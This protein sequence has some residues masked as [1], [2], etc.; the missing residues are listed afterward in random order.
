ML[1]LWSFLLQINTANIQI[2][3]RPINRTKWN[4][5]I[6]VGDYFNAFR[7]FNEHQAF[8]KHLHHKYPH[9][10]MSVV[11][12]SSTRNGESLE[13]VTISGGNTSM[14]T[15]RRELSKLPGLYIQSLVHGREWEAAM[16]ADFILS[17]FLEGYGVDREI[18][19]TMDSLQI[20]IIGI[21]NVDGFKY[22]WGQPQEHRM[23]RKNR[24]DNGDGSFGVDINR[25]WGPPNT[26]CT[27]GSSTDG[28]DETY[29][30]P[31]VE[32][33]PE[34]KAV[35]K[36]ITD[37]DHNVKVTVDIHSFGEKVL[38]PW[39]HSPDGRSVPKYHELK[40]LATKMAAA[41]N[42]VNG[43]GYK[44]EMGSHLYVHSGSMMDCLMSEYG[45][46]SF[47]IEVRGPWFDPHPISIRKA[48]QEVFA[49]IMALAETQ[50]TATGSSVEASFW[51]NGTSS[52]AWCWNCA[53]GVMIAIA[54]L[55]AVG[56]QTLYCM[57]Y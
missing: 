17:A 15:R 12:P 39:I 52:A 22:T 40:T 51:D 45:M 35:R 33:E 28:F 38:F 34:V 26:W 27:A 5:S 13:F 24:R 53:H 18:T 48:G 16:A 47:E 23:W 50:Y 21:V 1:F 3:H 44:A 57:G 54:S 9:N 36:F 19:E 42:A 10:S 56:F 2:G 31:S 46:L 29:C 8:I 11:F 20:H 55:I 25:N 30:G 4:A 43:E 14:R 7:D 37:K 6:P 32:S 49:G 41:M